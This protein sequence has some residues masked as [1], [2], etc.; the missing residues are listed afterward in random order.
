VVTKALHII[1]AG[2]IYLSSVG[3]VFNQHFCQN[4]LKEVAFFVKAK[5]CHSSMAMDGPPSCPMHRAMAEQQSTHEKGCCDDE[6]DLLKV[7]QPQS[8]EFPVLDLSPVFL[9]ALVQVLLVEMPS[10]DEHSVR[11]LNYKPP[12]IVCDHFSLLQTFLC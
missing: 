1:L 11:Y 6:A 5:S 9:A 12:L 7:D 3:L 4:E 10:T 2:L 8:F